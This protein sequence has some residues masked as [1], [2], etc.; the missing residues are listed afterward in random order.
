[1]G[2]YRKVRLRRWFHARLYQPKKYSHNPAKSRTIPHVQDYAR[3]SCSRPNGFTAITEAA[4]RASRFE[5]QGDKEQA[6][7]WRRIE[8][9]L[10]QM[11]GLHVS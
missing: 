1:L 11:R 9:A 7:T 6:Q 5:Q 3:G 10:L 8:A 4:Q 2:N